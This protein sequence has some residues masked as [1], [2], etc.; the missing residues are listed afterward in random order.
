VGL[1]D[2]LD[3]FEIELKS[4]RR[5][6]ETQKLYLSSIRRY[7]DWCADTGHPAQIDRGQVQ[8]WIAQLLDSGA[9]SATAA[10]RLAGVRQP[11]TGHTPQTLSSRGIRIS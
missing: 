7:L 10:A 11:I 5:S 2:S 6:P 1:A 9:Q 3:S 8:A 4:L